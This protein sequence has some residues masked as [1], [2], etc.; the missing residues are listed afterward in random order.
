MLVSPTA[1]SVNPEAVVERT[2]REIECHDLRNELHKAVVAK[3]IAELRNRD[4]QETDARI[5][6][7]QEKLK[8][9]EDA[10]PSPSDKR[11]R[12]PPD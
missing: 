3:T 10:P 4:T 9:L 5:R 6:T 8:E 7:L 1:L 11:E 12:L 2:K